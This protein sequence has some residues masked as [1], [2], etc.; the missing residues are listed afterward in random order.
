M[1]SPII[2]ITLILIVS[3]LTFSHFIKKFYKKE[4][5]TIFFLIKL[6]YSF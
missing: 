2:N 4:E 5:K 6:E 1:K 3:D